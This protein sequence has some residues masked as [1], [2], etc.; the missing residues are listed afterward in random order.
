M[1]EP[2]DAD[3][4]ERDARRAWAIFWAVLVFQALIDCNGLQLTVPTVRA[5]A[6]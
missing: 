1:S 5:L 6:R 3:R 4:D 2:D